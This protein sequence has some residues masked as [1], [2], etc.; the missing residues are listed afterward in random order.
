M[1]YFQQCRDNTEGDRCDRCLPGY[2][3][4]ATAG[5]PTDCRRCP[6]PLTTAPNQ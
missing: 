1:I 6:C 2:Y 5:T 4:D 3:G